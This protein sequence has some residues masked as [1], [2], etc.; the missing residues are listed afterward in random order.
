MTPSAISRNVSRLERALQTTLLQRT[1]R[2]LRLSGS[3]EEIYSHCLVML[4]AA[5]A[6]MESSGRFD[7]EPAGPVRISAPKAVARFVIHPHVASLLARFPKIDVRLLFDDRYMDLIEDDIDL[8][9][10]ITNQP[11]PGLMGR[12]LT[13]ITHLLGASPAYLATHGIPTHPVDLKKHSCICLGEEPA[14]SQW[15][16]YQSEKS[17]TVKVSGR[18]SANHTGARLDAALNN[19]GIASLPRFV[20]NEMLERGKIIRVLPDWEFRT[21]YAGD[22]WVLFPNTRH[23]PPKFRAV[24]DHLA[25]CINTER[26]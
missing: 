21:G 22:L 11:P 4:D 2:K 8:A 10:R 26:T 24:V 9:V 15:K 23:L 18:Y 19:I 3:G 20:A 7:R 13:T 1:T 16:F 14:D 5:R 6:V 25:S 17:V 12:K